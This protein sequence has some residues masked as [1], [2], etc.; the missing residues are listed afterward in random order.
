MPYV[1][2]LVKDCL[3]YEPAFC[4]AA[5]PFNL[6]IP[7]FIGKLQQAR[8]NA[9]FKVFQNT[10]GFPGIVR[11]LCPEPCKQV[12]T[13]KENG[14]AISLKLL[15][16]ASMNFARSPAPDQYNM[17]LKDATIAVIGAGISGMACALKLSAK[18]YRVTV[19]EK[20]GRI[21]GHLYNVLS[22]EIFLAD[23][24]LQFTHEN[25]TLKLNTEISDL[26][27][28][29]FDAVYIATG[30][31]GTTFGMTGAEEG[32]FATNTPGVFMGGSLTGADTMNAISQ[33]LAISSV[34]EAYLKTSKMAHSSAQINSTKLIYDA[35]R[36]IPGNTIL[37]ENG[38]DYTKEEAKNEAKRCLKCACK[39]CVHFSPLMNYFRKFP[40]RITEEVEVTIHPSTLDQAG[41]VATRLIA[42]CNHCGLC[43]E[44]CPQNIDTGEFLLQSHRRMHEKGAM[45]WA[46]HEYYL[47]DMEFSN[48]E[49]ALTKIPPGHQKSHYFFFP[50]CQLGASDPLYVTKSYRYLLGHYPDTA[51]MLG[52]CGIPADWAG[53]EKL[54][55]KVIK[56]IRED[57]DRIGKPAAIFTC[58]TC[59][60]TFQKYLPEIKGE[61][62]YGF[63][64]DVPVE[65]SH[66]S[67]QT[68]ASVYDPCASRYEPELQKT[69]RNLARKAG[70]TLDA[71]PMEG[72]LAECCSYGGQVAVAHPPYA[73]NMVQKRIS[74][75]QH[76]YITYCSNCRDIFASA[77]KNCWHILDVIFGAGPADRKPPSVS[78]RQVNRLNLKNQLLI[79]IWKEPVPMR[80]QKSILIISDELKEKLNKYYILESDIYK[81]IAYCEQS[82][83]KLFNPASGIYTG[84]LMIGNMTYWAEYKI[85]SDN[86]IELIN[87][88]CHR[89]KI[90]ES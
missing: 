14:G 88:Y 86:S 61:F 37:P 11:A 85:T 77:G 75:N 6:D 44:V 34:I 29:D 4:T 5:C 2:D 53:N 12:C 49:A 68:T 48:G 41:T 65:P 80:K 57:W 89:M 54:H 67:D 33:G 62:L 27:E 10:V 32:P 84:H 43:K 22:P 20:T 1:H 76:P 51:L 64:E 87:G 73:D 39:A 52:C 59:K 82:G 31:R 45:P 23:I 25:Y 90:E 70:F 42:T 46:F 78:G 26:G 16:A 18:K 63:F 3:Q 47:R 8:F 28:I 35:I 81:V 38:N 40:R 9:A 79:E 55:D 69:I 72:K 58:P 17:R 74:Q 15:E 30:E 83:I 13:L 66:Y 7:D 21:G 24:D 36:I 71:L 50:G 60:Q 56:K 19:F